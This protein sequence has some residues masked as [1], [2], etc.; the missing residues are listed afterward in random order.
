MCCTTQDCGDVM[1]YCK[2]A[3]DNGRMAVGVDY[4]LDEILDNLPKLVEEQDNNKKIQFTEDWAKDLMGKLQ[5]KNVKMPET[6]RN[7]MC[8]IRS[9][10]VS[11]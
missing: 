2:D 9:D 4:C 5:T 8:D 1:E 11:T 3:V 7:M 10:G 6:L